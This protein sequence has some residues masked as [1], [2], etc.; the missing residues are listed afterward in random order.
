MA[1]EKVGVAKGLGSKKLLTNLKKKTNPK[2]QRSKTA[3]GGGIN[4]R[5]YKKEQL[6]MTNKKPQEPTTLQKEN[7]RKNFQRGPMADQRA[8]AMA[9]A[10]AIGVQRSTAGGKRFRVSR[11]LKIRVF[12]AFKTHA[13]IST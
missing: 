5:W 8:M 7:R 11:F 13:L 9:V 10:A 3:G 2:R 12:R 4:G 6:E 1:T